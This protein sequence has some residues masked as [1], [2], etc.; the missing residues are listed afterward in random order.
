MQ[1]TC[2]KCGGKTDVKLRADGGYSPVGP[3]IGFCPVVKER[4]EKNGGRADDAHCDHM[5]KAAQEV[6]Y[7]MRGGR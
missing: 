5:A 2:L 3:L 1:A 4:A 7:G 6:A